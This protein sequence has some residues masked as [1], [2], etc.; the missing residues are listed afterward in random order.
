MQLHEIE[1][2]LGIPQKQ[3]VTA[4]T[5]SPP[6]K[7][8]TARHDDMF[9]ETAALEQQTPSATPIT[10]PHVSYAGVA[11]IVKVLWEEEEETTFEP[12][13]QKNTPAMLWHYQAEIVGHLRRHNFSHLTVYDA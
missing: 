6:S 11:R 8:S 10:S 12:D 3:G 2:M 1:I 13:I 9:P 7:A 4:R 5:V